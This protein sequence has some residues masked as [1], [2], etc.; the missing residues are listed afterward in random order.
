MTCKQEMPR[1]SLTINAHQYHNIKGSSFALH[2]VSLRK[3]AY[4]GEMGS[5]AWPEHWMRMA[6]QWHSKDGM[7]GELQQKPYLLANKITLIQ[8]NEHYTM[9]SS[10]YTRGIG[11]FNHIKCQSLRRAKWVSCWY[12][13]SISYQSKER[14]HSTLQSKFRCTQLK[15]YLP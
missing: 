6:V 2:E 10:D 12:E 11:P 4:C 7:T 15:S 8:L 14:I 9:H 3:V 13:N 5:G 1:I